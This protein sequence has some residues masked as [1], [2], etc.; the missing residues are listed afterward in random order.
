VEEPN[1]RAILQALYRLA[2]DSG[3]L[4][5]A[6][7]LERLPDERQRDMVAR[8]VLEP[9]GDEA[10]QQQ[11]DDCLTALQRRGIE[12]QLKGLKEGMHEAE[13]RG[14][15]VRLAH[16]QQ[17]FAELRRTLIKRARPAPHRPERQVASGGEPPT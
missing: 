12:V 1:L 17:Q 5:V 15:M 2:S 13:R 11:I 4:E 9:L 8:L 16:L 14:D 6:G 10:V 7:L 3:E